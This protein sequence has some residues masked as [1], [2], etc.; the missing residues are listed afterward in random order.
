MIINVNKKMYYSTY[1]NN[2]DVVAA[3]CINEL[4][5]LIQLVEFVQDRQMLKDM[6]NHCER[7]IDTDIPMHLHKM[8]DIIPS[9][10]DKCYTGRVIYMQSPSQTVV[11]PSSITIDMLADEVIEFIENTGGIEEAPIDDK[12]YARKNAAWAEVEGGGGSV[13]M[14]KPLVKPTLT[15]T[16]TNKRTGSTSSSLSLSSE[17]G[18]IYS[19]SGIYMWASNEEYKDPQSMESNVFTELTK[20]GEP[21]QVVQKD[22]AV[23]ANYYIT[24]KAPKIGFEVVDGKLVPAT[25]EDKQT[26]NSSINFLYPVYYGVEGKLKKQLVSSAN[27]TITNI[28]TGSSEYF[29]YKYPS[30]YAKLSTITMNDAYNVTQAFN[31]SEEQITTDTGM[32]LTMRVYTSANPGAFT[33]AKLNF[34]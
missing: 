20:D 1:I 19:W 22:T 29:V 32:N 5:K 17:I 11:G 33:N 30:N 26:V 10:D 3:I 13:E 18:D 28:T 2:R 21:S 25:G 23:N 27:L 7:Q 8:C 31:Y 14:D 24:L 12:Q 6:I 34:K 15:V 9:E 16:W 4:N